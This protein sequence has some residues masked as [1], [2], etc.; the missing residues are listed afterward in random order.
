MFE[1]SIWILKF[2]WLV[3][4]LDIS[5]FILKMCFRKSCKDIS[6]SPGRIFQSRTCPLLHRDDLVR[7]PGVGPLSPILPGQF[8]VCPG[9]LTVE[10]FDCLVI[11]TVGTLDALGLKTLNIIK[12]KT[13]S[14]N[15]LII[16][17]DTDLIL[18][19][20]I[21]TTTIISTQ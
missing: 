9:W 6:D 21:Y 13:L 11:R 2:S 3:F 5:R 4:K 18:K 8:L 12:T 15:I 19:H 20:P 10:Y 16:L 1:S 7:R 17:I 14:K